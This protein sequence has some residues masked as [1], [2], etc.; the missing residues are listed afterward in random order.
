MG[1]ELLQIGDWAYLRKEKS[2]LRFSFPKRH[3]SDIPLAGLIIQG[4]PKADFLENTS[5][6]SNLQQ[7]TW[8]IMENVK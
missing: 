6:T 2:A 1:M 8:E 5:L 7:F 3:A 4:N